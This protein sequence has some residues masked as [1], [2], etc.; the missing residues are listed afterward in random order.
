MSQKEPTTELQVTMEQLLR[1]MVDKSASDLHLTVGNAP[2]LRIDG[3]VLPLKLAP[4]TGDHV[5]QLLYSVLTEDQKVSFERSSEV[6]FSFGI[7]GVSRFRANAFLQRA[8]VAAVF[9]QI[10]LRIPPMEELGL[11]PIVADLCKK[12]RG[13]VLVTGPTGSGKSTTLASMIDKINSEERMHILTIEDPIEYWHP[14]K[15]CVVNQRQIGQDTANFGTALKYA[16]RQDPDVILVGELRDLET[17]SAALTAAETGHLVF[18]TLHTNSAISTVNR[19][20]DVFP[21]H[22]QAQVRA[23]LSFSLVAVMTQLLMPRASGQGRAMAMEIMVPNPAIRNLIR[24]D[25]LHQIYSQM[26]VGQGES[27]MQTMNQNL[28]TLVQRNVIALDDALNASSDVDELKQ[29]LAMRAAPA[30]VRR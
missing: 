25:K 16:L 5:K 21:P 29:M 28:A 2:L 9:R 12:P 26:Q 24:E 17:V 14:H 11:P 20:I 30:H 6:D 19:I 4:L 23:Q 27:G 10:P 22:Q 18:A 15:L 3:Q 1:V 7:R 13:L 8:N